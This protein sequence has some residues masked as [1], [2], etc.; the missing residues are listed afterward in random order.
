M[1][2]IIF[3]IMLLTISLS[4]FA[5]PS[6]NT[7]IP[8][9]DY[10]SNDWDGDGISN[11]E[12][13]DDDNDGI[14]DADDSMKFGQAGRNSTPDVIV[15]SFFAN[16]ISYLPGEKLRLTWYVDNIRSLNLYNK[17]SNIHLGDMKNNSSIEV[18]PSSDVI[19]EIDAETSKHQLR[20]YVYQENN[21]N[22][23][24]W[25]PE[26][27]TITNG[28]S[29]IQTR[30][31]NINYSS[32]EPNVITENVNENK[33][34]IGLLVS[35]ECH[36]MEKWSY[37]WQAVEDRYNRI[38]DI[39]LY[40]KGVGLVHRLTKY[41]K[42]YTNKYFDVDGFRYSIG[43]FDYTYRKRSADDHFYGICREPI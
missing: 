14:N 31:C 10:I 1:K 17:T 36:T 25:S 8:Q 22:C 33:S 2:K 24:N 41:G 3:A 39:R 28:Q 15:H 43:E 35:K 13:P 11:S 38:F 26:A 27:S 23:S 30:N 34:E 16:K 12:D 20:V 37:V 18:S 6:F 42:N 19:Y 5:A 9:P 40:W 21:R 4:S 29:F 32:E 7:K